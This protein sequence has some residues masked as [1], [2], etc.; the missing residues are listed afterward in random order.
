MAIR[1]SEED[2]I[3]KRLK[4]EWE[5]LYKTIVGFADEG[6]TASQIIKRHSIKGIRIDN[7]EETFPFTNTNNFR[8]YLLDMCAEIEK[9]PPKFEERR[10]KKSDD[11]D[12]DD[13]YEDDDDKKESKGKRKEFLQRV[14]SKDR[15]AKK[16][17]SLPQS[18]FD[19][20]RIGE[21]GENNERYDVEKKERI[22]DGEQLN[23][24]YIKMVLKKEARTSKKIIVELTK[25]N[26]DDVEN[27]EK[28]YG[29]KLN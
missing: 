19:H 11:D 6:M 16:I 12:D 29:K 10:K 14:R 5:R 25:A 13:D 18:M 26:D 1:T 17:C 9:V 3:K 15:G 21:F 4:A 27:Y 2:R 28:K 23:D 8:S 22:A 20:L 24:Y 7:P